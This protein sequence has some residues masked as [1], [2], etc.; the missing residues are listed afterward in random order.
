MLNQIKPITTKNPELI[1]CLSRFL[2]YPFIKEYAH[3]PFSENYLPQYGLNL[4]C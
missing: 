2:I 1:N 4:Y 3:I